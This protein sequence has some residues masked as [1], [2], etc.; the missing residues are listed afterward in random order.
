MEYVGGI[1]KVPPNPSR[2]KRAVSV[3]EP[4]WPGFRQCKRGIWTDGLCKQHHPDTEAQRVKERDERYHRRYENSTV[5]Q[6]ARLR[7]KHKVILHQRDELLKVC[8]RRMDKYSIFLSYAKGLHRILVNAI[9]L[10]EGD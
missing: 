1:G 4:R 8:K 3:G 10:V 9:A 6:L 2:C 7:K 5:V